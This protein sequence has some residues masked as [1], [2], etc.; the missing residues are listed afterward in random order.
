ML[1]FFLLP[2]V[3]LVS[4]IGNQKVSPKWPLLGACV[5]IPWLINDSESMALT[6]LFST[7]VAAKK[8]E[9]RVERLRFKGRCRLVKRI[10][11][12]SVCASLYLSM[13]TSVLLLNVKVTSKDGTQVSCKLFF[14]RK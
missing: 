14:G 7:V 3:F 13:W 9:W 4:N 6:A 5:S 12:L 2:G 11:V 8:R 10:L 1:Y